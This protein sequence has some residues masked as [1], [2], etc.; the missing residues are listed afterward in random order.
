ME[1]NE[2]ELKECICAK[3]GKIEFR[4]NFESLCSKCQWKLNRVIKKCKIVE[5]EKINSTTTNSIA[6]DDNNE[7]E[8]AEECLNDNGYDCEN[9]D[10]SILKVP[11]VEEEEE[12]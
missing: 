3:C 1:L 10:F 6:I 8:L 7:V 5:S 2:P 12:E 4:N 11:E 9:Y